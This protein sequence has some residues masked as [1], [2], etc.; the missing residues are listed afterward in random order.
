MDQ[1]SQHEEK[2]E[3]QEVGG[4]G[5]IKPESEPE[6]A[7]VLDPTSTELGLPAQ[8][9]PSRFEEFDDLI[10]KLSQD[11]AEEE[12]STL[13]KITQEAKQDGQVQTDD[14]INGAHWFDYADHEK[15]EGEKEDGAIIVNLFGSPSPEVRSPVE[16]DPE[17]S[18]DTPSAAEPPPFIDPDL[19]NVQPDPFVDSGNLWEVDLVVGGDPDVDEGDPDAV[20]SADE[21]EGIDEDDPIYEVMDIEEE[22]VQK[23]NIEKP[24][25][26]D[27]DGVTADS[28]HYLLAG[29]LLEMADAGQ[30]RPTSHF[31]CMPFNC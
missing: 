18:E 22:Q 11:A 24:D 8:P 29:K 16:M 28:P 2:E 23:V 20:W 14:E 19:D 25:S 5:G 3:A 27:E 12:R 10:V 21:E 13:N 4:G 17:E 9:R 7:Q 26:I 6:Q 1:G 31:A 30:R 15:L